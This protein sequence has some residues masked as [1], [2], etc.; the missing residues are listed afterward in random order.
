NSVTYP[1]FVTATNGELAFI[2]RD[3]GSGGGNH[4]LNGWNP[5]TRSWNRLLA[6]DL[7]SGASTTGTRSVYFG[8]NDAGP[9]AGPDGRY[10]LFWF[11]RGTSDAATTHRVSYIRSP[12]LTN[13]FTASGTPVTLPVTF[14]N[15][16]GVVVDDVPRYAG[17]IN[18]GQIG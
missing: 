5:D 10:H 3:G 13:W 14:D 11:W 8:D 15:N 18:R 9:V 6:T 17:L 7:F 2:Y 1:V 16:P 4:V 12:D